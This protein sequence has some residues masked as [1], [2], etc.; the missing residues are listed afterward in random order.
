MNKQKERSKGAAKTEKGDWTVIFED[1]KQTLYI[2]CKLSTFFT[3]DFLDNKKPFFKRIFLSNLISIPFI[4][5][6]FIIII[7]Y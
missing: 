4:L 3:T 1:N 5:T 2:F 6:F 7:N